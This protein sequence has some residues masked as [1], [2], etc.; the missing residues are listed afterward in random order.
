MIPQYFVYV[1]APAY[2]EQW[3]KHTYGAPD[4]PYVSFP[5]GSAPAAIMQ[6][7]LRQ[8][9]VGW[10]YGNTDGKVKIAVPPI[11]GLKT[12]TF[13][14]LSPDGEAALVSACKKLFQA[15]LYLEL[16]E[17][18]SHDVQITNVIYDFMDRHGIERDEKN[19]ET[20]RQMYARMRKKSLL[21][22]S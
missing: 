20:I 21:T 19:W 15:R 12:G 10:T 22:K 17:L 6:A 4:S 16:H 1:S 5:R 3:L 18:F 7:S 9:P 11:K 13:C 2:L 8:P 14:Y